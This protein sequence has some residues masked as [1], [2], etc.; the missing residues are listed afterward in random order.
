MEFPRLPAASLFDDRGE[1]SAA[2]NVARGAA[3]LDQEFPGWERQI[4]LAREADTYDH[5]WEGGY[6]TISDAIV[7]RNRVTVEKFA[8][9]P[10][11]RRRSRW[12][13]PRWP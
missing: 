3:W 12:P 8:T 7:F 4:D 6:L 9:P 1:Y 10:D 5:V 13:G 2:A 11:A